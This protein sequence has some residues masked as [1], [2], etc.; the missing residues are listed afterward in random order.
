MKIV[1]VYNAND[2]LAVGSPPTDYNCN[3]K[4]RQNIP[5]GT[6]SWAQLAAL[7]NGG[8]CSVPPGNPDSITNLKLDNLSTPGQYTATTA[9]VVLNVTL[10]RQAVVQWTLHTNGTAGPCGIAPP[11]DNS[12]ICVVLEYHGSTLTGD[13]PDP[14]NN[15][16]VVRLCDLNL[17]N[18]LDQQT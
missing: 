8:T 3:A 6:Y 13:Y 10:P 5:A 15:G 2:P 9:G 4:A 12:A 7:T 14:Q 1:T 11:A 16:T 18:C 17:G